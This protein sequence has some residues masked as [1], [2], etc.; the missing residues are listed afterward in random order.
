MKITT[1]VIVSILVCLMIAGCASRGGFGPRTEYV[2]LEVT[3]YCKC[4]QCCGWKRNLLMQPVHA[5]GPHKGKKKEVG[6]TASGTK[7]QIGTIAADTDVY[8]FG[9]RMHVPGYGWGTVEDRGGAIKGGRIDLFFNSHED[10]LRWGRQTVK[11][12]IVR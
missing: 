1:S 7:A 9:T 5:Y 11:V 12:Q 2:S 3:G 6:V 10:A 4:G 8:P